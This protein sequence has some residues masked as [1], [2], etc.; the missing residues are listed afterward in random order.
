MAVSR[1]S[2]LS[3]KQVLFSLYP[4]NLSF[5]LPLVGGWLEG[6]L[7]YFRTIIKVRVEK[8]LSLQSGLGLHRFVHFLTSTTSV[9]LWL[10]CC[11]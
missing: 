7:N 6:R 5:L 11:V 2:I 10:L 9:Y 4:K 1:W 3:S 8:N